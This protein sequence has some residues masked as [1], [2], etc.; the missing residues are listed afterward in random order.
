VVVD[1]LM[2][3]LG[4]L[5]YETLRQWLG[6]AD[7]QQLARAAGDMAAVE[8]VL[9]NQRVF[10][11]LRNIGWPPAGAPGSLPPKVPP[12]PAPSGETPSAANAP[13]ENAPPLPWG[14]ALLGPGLL[15]DRAGLFPTGRLRDLLI[16]YIG[17]TG[18]LGVLSLLDIGI[19]AE[20]DTAG[21]A[22]SPLGGWRRQF[23][24]FTVFSFQRE[25][26]EEVTPRLRFEPAPR[27][28]QVRLHV[29]DVSQARITASLNDFLYARTRQS[30]LSNLRLLQVLN[31]QLHVPLAAC[32]ETAESLLDAKLI[33]P[34]GGKYVLAGGG[35]GE[36]PPHWTSTALGPS[37]PAGFL[38]ARAPQGYQSPPLNWF[39]GLALD[40]MM[41]EKTISAHAKIIMQT[42]PKR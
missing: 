29:E 7:R 32:K 17:T 26:L 12:P 20:S 31:Q 25:V 34:L 11:G 10:A 22:S 8:L 19:P 6:S 15:S 36:A 3:P 1:V 38:A 28:A 39:R 33:C 14:G 40:A 4:P 27:P 30:S 41:N 5:H 16:G 2:S 23:D 42:P 21:Y 37:E 35:Q 18:D 24:R 9:N 13:R